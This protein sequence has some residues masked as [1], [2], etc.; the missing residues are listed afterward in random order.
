MKNKEMSEIFESKIRSIRANW[1]HELAKVLWQFRDTSMTSDELAEL[2]GTTKKTV[3]KG[4][5]ILKN[6]HGF[7]VVNNAICNQTASYQLVS[8]NTNPEYKHFMDT[9]GWSGVEVRKSA[10][11][12]KQEMAKPTYTHIQKLALGLTL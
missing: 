2:T 12:P 1:L 5:N 11:K 8:F 10:K 4:V 6:K 3:T 9:G 7:D